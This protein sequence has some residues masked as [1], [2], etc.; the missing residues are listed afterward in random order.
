MNSRPL[1]HVSGDP[2]DEPVLTPNHFLVGQSG[3][4]V[5]PESV[6]CTPFNPQET[7]EARAG[8]YSPNLETLDARVPYKSWVPIKVV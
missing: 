2:N 8:T 7:L 4:D 1:T 3:G 6:N 5:A